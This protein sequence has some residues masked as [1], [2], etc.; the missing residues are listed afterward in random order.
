MKKRL[1]PINRKFI[2]RIAE[3]EGLFPKQ[4]ENIIIP[5]FEYMK[6]MI[7]SDEAM[8]FNIPYIGKFLVNEKALEGRRKHLDKKYGTN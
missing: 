7:P 6:K 1:D 5:Q 4:V 2:E 8:Q 3:E